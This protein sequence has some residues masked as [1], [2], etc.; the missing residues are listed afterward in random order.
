RIRYESA[1]DSDGPLDSFASLIQPNHAQARPG[2]ID[3]RGADFFA[4]LEQFVD[5]AVFHGTVGVAHDFFTTCNGRLNRVEVLLGKGHI[6]V[7]SDNRWWSCGVEVA[8]LPAAM[9]RSE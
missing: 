9:A 2:S 4:R 7:S 8:V 5:G 3:Q 6:S 1:S